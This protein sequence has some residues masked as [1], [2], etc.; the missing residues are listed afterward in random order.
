MAARKLVGLV[1]SPRVPEAAEFVASIVKSLGIE[2]SSWVAS[3]AELN[4][5]ADMMAETSAIVTVGGD[6]TILRVVR[7]AAPYSVPMVGVN[8]GRVG[9][10]TELTVDKAEEELP[11]YLNGGARVEER[12]MLQASVRSAPEAD[13][14]LVVHALNDVVLTRGSIARLL[15][16]ETKIDGV[17][18]AT[19]RAD[20]VIV[21]TP[22]GSTGYALSAG[23]PI[24]YPEAQEILLQPLAAHMSFQTGIVVS[25]DSVIRLSAQGDQEAVLS[26]DGFSDTTIGRDHVVSI[27]KSPEVARF[28]RGDPPSAFYS[29]LTMGLGVSGR[30]VPP[31][32]Q[33]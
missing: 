18:L 6:G 2:D 14:H 12:L 15:D 22:T 29:T 7:F 28:L 32:P 17:L 21:A 27:E 25:A 5:S 24:L 9:F 19:Y 16:I 20:G 26:A 11:R 23:G 3:T 13:P 30:R 31:A 10:M 33:T 4:V 1:H 8:M